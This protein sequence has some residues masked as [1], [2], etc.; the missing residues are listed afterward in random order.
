MFNFL[1]LKP[2]Q[3]DFTHM[4]DTLGIN[5]LIKTNEVIEASF[6]DLYSRKPWGDF[7]YIFKNYIK[8]PFTNYCKSPS[9]I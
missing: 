5:V 8:N 7:Y 4:E 9:K 3:A 6:S 2:G 1:L